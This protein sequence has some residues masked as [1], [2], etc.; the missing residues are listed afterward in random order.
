MRRQ[1]PISAVI[2]QHFKE[3]SSIYLFVFV[4]FLMGVIF[5]AIIVNSMNASQKEDLYYYLNR[6][7]GQVAE[8]KVASS[9][10]MFQQS[11]SHNLKYLGLMWVLG[12]SIIGL[13][14]ILVMLFIKGMVVGFTVGFLVN[15]LG[16]KG[17]LLSFI[18]VLPQNILLIP[19][20]IIMCSVAISFTLK[21]IKQL[22]V[23]RSNNLEAPFSLFARYAMIFI[24]IG[25]LALAASGFE[26]YA[27][28]YLMKNVVELVSK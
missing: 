5:G 16:L 8:G 9:A 10:E 22:F 17:F 25:A 21:I 23:K 13:P 2:K 12:I 11:F 20:F 18:S 15:Q 3:Q 26:A 7:F 6:F 27:S 19:A 14:V 28:P 4:L 24:F 1:L